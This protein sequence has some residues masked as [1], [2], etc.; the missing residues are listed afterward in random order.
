MSKIVVTGSTGQLGSELCKILEDKWSVVGL[1][2]G[3]MAN[4]CIELT[5]K[6]QVERTIN[7]L[8]PTIVVN[9]AAYTNVDAAERYPHVAFRHNGLGVRHL[10]KA[11]QNIGAVLIHISTDYVFGQAKNR[12][13]PYHPGDCVNPVNAYGVSKVTGEYFVRIECTKHYIIRTSGLYGINGNNFIK[14]VIELGNC[15]N[16]LNIVDD[17]ILSPTNAKDLAEQIKLTIERIN[18]YPWLLP[19]G[20]YHVV[21]RGGTSWYNLTKTI[22]EF[23]GIKTEV[24]ARKTDAKFLEKRADRPRY[25]VLDNFGFDHF[26]RKK[27]RTWKAALEDFLENYLKES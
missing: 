6:N 16:W 11:C 25:S 8:K 17:Q 27:M 19:Y 18:E 21:N 15:S 20:T 22:F 12:K 7:R 4:D 3:R 13:K 24:R 5:D 23:C 2:H 9:T 10:A 26:T 14:K 1:K